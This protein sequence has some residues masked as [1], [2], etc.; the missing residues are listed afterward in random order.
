MA[1]LDVDTTTT[2]DDTSAPEPT[3]REVEGDG[4]FSRIEA[5]R[6]QEK[7]KLYPVIERLRKD[8]HDLSVRAEAAEKAVKDLE[9][10]MAD[11]SAAYEKRIEEQASQIQS[12]RSDLDSVKATMETTAK[13]ARASQLRAYRKDQVAGLDEEFSALVPETAGSQEEIDAAVSKARALQERMVRKLEEERLKAAGESVPRPVA[14]TGGQAHSESGGASI[15]FSPL[16]R[17]AAARLS[18]EE[19]ARI[20]EQKLADA[21]RAMARR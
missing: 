17:M 7:A 11:S 3:R 8:N 4:Q 18:E 2:Q 15:G 10:K 13:E 14:P 21:R 9:Q 20:R 12:L 19:Y 6:Q 16:D 5:A 1:D